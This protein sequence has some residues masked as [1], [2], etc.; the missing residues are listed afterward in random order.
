MMKG[1]KTMENIFT[2]RSGREFI[3]REV[4]E[5][6]VEK[7]L[8]AAMQTNYAGSEQPWEFI[9]VKDKKVLSEISAMEEHLEV[10]KDSSCAVVVLTDMRKL[11][12]PDNWHQDMAAAVQNMLLEATNQGL[13]AVWLGVAPVEAR[14]DFMIDYFDLP[15]NIMPFGVVPVGYF[16]DECNVFVDRFD[17]SKVHYNQW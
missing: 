15:E 16:E 1:G 2:K 6:K 4:E 3:E 5:D 7:L 8:R 11:F 12:S 10:L 17:S 14:M 9:V 13:E